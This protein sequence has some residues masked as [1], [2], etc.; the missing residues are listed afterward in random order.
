MDLIPF[1]P[2]DARQVLTTIRQLRASGILSAGFIDQILKRWPRTLGGDG[3]GQL[4]FFK[5]VEDYRPSGTLAR[6][7]DRSGTVYSPDSPAVK[8]HHQWNKPA[9][10]N[11][12]YLALCYNTGAKWEFLQGKCPDLSCDEAAS[13]IDLGTPPEATVN[14]VYEHEIVVND[15]AAAPTITGLP[16]GLTAT[17]EETGDDQWTITITGTPTTAGEFTIIVSGTTLENDCPI[18]AAFNLLVN[19]CD[20]G[21]SEIDIGELPEAT[22]FEEYDHEITFTDVDDIEI[23]GLPPEIDATIGS[24]TITLHSDEL[25]AKGVWQVTITGT[26][27]ENGCPIQVQFVINIGPCDASGA[28]YLTPPKDQLTWAIRPNLFDCCVGSFNTAFIAAYEIENVSAS[29]LPDW[30]TLAVISEGEWG[31]S[32]QIQGT[33]IT[34]NCDIDEAVYDG[35][36]L[37]SNPFAFG[38]WWYWDVELTGDSIPNGCQVKTTVRVWLQVICDQCPEPTD[39]DTLGAS[40]SWNPILP[41][42]PYNWTTSGSGISAVVDWDNVTNISVSGEPANSVVDIGTDEA[43]PSSVVIGPGGTNTAGTYVVTI[44][45]EVASGEHAGCPISFTYTFQVV[46]D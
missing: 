10:A 31:S 15:F 35:G 23:L 30:L 37:G 39:Y 28:Y 25:P 26:T 42:P 12:G 20:V 40:F 16:D 6:R 21:D 3:A 41:S 43:Y 17:I 33:P 24:G 29:G 38:D 46:E 19:P 5:F 18:E 45:G 9:G 27:P 2:Q 44:T 22:E 34:D 32:V 11:S 7:C 14:E 36:T 1:T 13:S 4:Q 8:V